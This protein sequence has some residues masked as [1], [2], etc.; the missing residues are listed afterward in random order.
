MRA[1]ARARQLDQLSPEPG[2]IRINGS[3][4]DRARRPDAVLVL[5]AVHDGQEPVIAEDAIRPRLRSGAP[6][7]GESSCNARSTAGYGVDRP[8][9]SR[10]V[11]E[12]LG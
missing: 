5:A 4:T 8:S 2:S 9:T 12:E 1:E 10:K 7:E 11:A 3:A 6:R